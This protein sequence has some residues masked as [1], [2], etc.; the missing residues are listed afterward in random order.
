MAES[1]TKNRQYNE[2]YLRIIEQREDDEADRR[3]AW[4]YMLHSTAVFDGRPV[5]SSYMPKFFDA[6]T[7]KRFEYIAETTDRILGKVMREYLENPTYRRVYDLDERLVELIL[8]PRDYDAMLPYARVDLFLDE[9]TLEATF[10]EFNADGSSGMNEDRE[11]A[12]S[13]ANSAPW[14]E[15]AAKH[16]VQTGEKALFDGWVDEFLRI[17]D[18]Y[19]FK[20]EQPRIAIVDFLE[21]AVTEEFK[22]YGKLFEERGLE[23]AVY[24]VRELEFTD[25]KLVGRTAFVGAD[26]MP[27]DAI[28]RR[29]VTSDIIDHWE[30]SQ[31]LIEA[32]RQ[33]KVALIGSFAG[34][35][36]HDK[37]IFRVLFDPATKAILTDEEN[38]FIEETV[39]FTTFLG[40]EYIDLEAVKAEPEKWIIKPTDAYGSRNVHAGRDHTAEEW[41][42]LI[43]SHADGRSGAPFLVQRFCV[44]FQTPTLP[45]YDREEDYTA[46]ARMYYNLSGLYLHD[47]KFAGVFSRQGPGNI[48]LG[49]FGGVTAVSTWVED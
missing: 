31:P 21:N 20:V 18:T 22:V 33:Q 7:R 47:G 49:K 39:P 12:A 37:Q 44:P 3:A 4:D 13:I 10:C 38:A 24:D 17:Y 36:V 34:H 27:I 25:G 35:L 30:E 48:I 19:R 15:F 32:V 5:W 23:F 28:W 14:K 43:D 41:A 8:L 6:A 11:V 40:E 42:E 45:F 16:R 26:N 2:E 29:S 9:D 1:K 46:S